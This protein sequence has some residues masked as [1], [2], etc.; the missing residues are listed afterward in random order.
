MPDDN[1]EAKIVEGA[2]GK[3]SLENFYTPLEEAKKE[4]WRRWNDNKLKSEVDDYLVEIPEIFRERPEA[5]LFRNIATPDFEFQRAQNIAKDLDLKPLYLEYLSDRFCTR[6]LDK[7]YLGKMAF[8]H[9]RDKDGSCV[10]SKRKLFDLKENDGKMFEDVFTDAGEN[11]INFHHDLFKPLY[12]DVSVYDVSRWIKKKGKNALE[13]YPY[14]IALFLCH[15]VLL[16]SYNMNSSEEQKFVRNIVIPSFNKVLNVFGVKPLIIKL[17]SDKEV[18]D[19]Y[20]YCHPQFL[21]QFIDKK[22]V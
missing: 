20:W 12:P 21:L 18:S 13:N 22:Q 7:L 16:E 4:I 1:E 6:S 19:L 8:F 9:C 17:F 14:F 15:G 2:D 5:V 11:I 3:L 10:T